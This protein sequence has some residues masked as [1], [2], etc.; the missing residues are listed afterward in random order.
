MTKLFRKN[1]FNKCP[2]S[3]KPCWLFCI[4]WAQE[5]YFLLFKEQ[6]QTRYVF[7]FLKEQ[8]QKC[9]GFS[10]NRKK[11]PRRILNC[12]LST[13]TRLPYGHAHFSR[14]TINMYLPTLPKQFCHARKNLNRSK[15]NT[16]WSCNL[17]GPSSATRV[18]CW[19]PSLSAY[20]TGFNRSFLLNDKT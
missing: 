2:K 8:R 17:Y 10:K 6:R 11:R 12:H 16:Y 19:S 20:I 14:D 1:G 15:S 18:A 5:K 9:Y 7:T 3:F 13:T 4:L